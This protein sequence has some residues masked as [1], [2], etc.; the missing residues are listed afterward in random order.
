ME[1]EHLELLKNACKCIGKA[2]LKTKLSKCLFFQEQVQYLGQ[3]V[4]GASIFSLTGKIEAFMK[5]K[6][7]TNIKEARHFLGL[8]GYYRK[9]TCNY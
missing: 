4:C 8:T 2:S 3:L 1:K 7:P 6:L 9:C 5:L